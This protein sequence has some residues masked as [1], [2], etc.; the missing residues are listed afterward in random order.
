ML[1]NNLKVA[2]AVLLVTATLGLGVG[3]G[4]VLVWQSRA[5]E[6]GSSPGEL[7]AKDRDED[8]LTNTL[9]ALEKHRWRAGERGEWQEEAKLLADDLL[10]VSSYGRNGKAASVEAAKHLRVAGWAL[11]DAEVRRVSQD[12]AVLT[13]VYDCKVFSQAGE[14]LQTRRNHRASEVW[15]LRKGGWVIVFC[16]ETVLP[17]GE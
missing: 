8:N 5:A 1:V 16:Q 12:V 2:T 6:T 9:L 10:T 17:G 13:Y 3:V 14:L 7:S 4:G 11:R 15:A